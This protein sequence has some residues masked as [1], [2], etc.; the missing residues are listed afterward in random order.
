MNWIFAALL[1]VL[2]VELAL[3]L[4]FKPVIVGLTQSSRKALRV[5]RS[6]AISDHWKEKVMGAYAQQTFLN[7]AKLT[8]LLVALFGTAT[9]IVLALNLL[10]SGFAN[11]IIGPI[12][13]IAT[14]VL[15]SGYF[16][17][18]RPG[19]KAHAGNGYSAL[20][21]LLHRLALQ[22]APLAEL[23]FDIDQSMARSNQSVPPV[24]DLRN[25]RHVFV[26]GLARAGTT[27]LMRRFHATG[28]F[29]SL[30]YRDMPFVLAPNFWQKIA[31]RN[32]RDL[33][34]GE[35]AHG[36]RLVVDADSPESLDEV[37]WRVFCGHDYIQTDHLRSH[38]PD[39]DTIQRFASYVRAILCAE[40]PPKTRYLSKNNN[41]ILR[42][43]AIRSA[44]P[45]ALILIPFR[46]PLSH[47]ASLHHQH[48]QFQSSQA[49]DPFIQTYMTWL[50]HHEF[51]HGHRPFRLE[52]QAL[53]YSANSLD[54][55]L[56][57]WCQVYRWLE[58]TKPADA[59][60]VCYEQLCTDP[61]YWTMLA[62]QAGLES[63]RNA[64]EAFELSTTTATG[65]DPQLLADA[66]DIYQRL[67]AL[68]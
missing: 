29:R 61:N 28:E 68:S 11:F 66:N 27:V 17:I 13:L 37:F 48:Q 64:Y 57:L 40:D 51:G 25:Q 32:K 6:N 65:A 45:N 30:T 7:T 59:Q 42:L 18:R 49:E 41:N 23:S 9:L 20:D 3:R 67:K 22:F 1:C 43:G 36:D 10:G 53:S 58:A 15:A 8:G 35:R 12:G 46:E 5:V 21:K 60:F 54:Y 33:K 52:N 24:E 39:P 56:T 26:T 63:S 62:E 16:M 2:L 55:W 31:G 44:F 38:Q 34:A 14:L 50:A 19:N 4:P 47:A